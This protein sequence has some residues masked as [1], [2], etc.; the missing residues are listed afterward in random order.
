MQGRNE[1]SCCKHLTSVI[2]IMS[3]SIPGDPNFDKEFLKDVSASIKELKT[4][5]K[6]L[7]NKTLYEVKSM[8]FEGIAVCEKYQWV[9]QK[10]STSLVGGRR[11]RS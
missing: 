10:Q 6:N 3:K 2:S 5:V 11:R 7:D 1:R 4:N 9:R 8:L